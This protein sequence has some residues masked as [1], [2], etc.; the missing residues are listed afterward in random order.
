MCETE[1]TEIFEL[2]EFIKL[3]DFGGDIVVYLEAVYQIFKEDF[4]DSKPVY[5][6]TQLRLKR[7]PLVEGKEATFY[8]MTHKGDNEKYR[9][10]DIRRMER[11]AWPRPVIDDS[12]HPY[13]KVWRNIRRGRG[14]KK[15]RI[16]ILHTEERYLVVLDDRKNYILPWTAYLLRSEHELDKKLQEYERYQNTETAR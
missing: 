1:N 7:Y 3:T 10:P 9:E 8:H 13:L 12:E 15:E 14:G 11:I 2:P 16:L 6:G 4:V 5:R